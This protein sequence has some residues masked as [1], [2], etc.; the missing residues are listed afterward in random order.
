MNFDHLRKPNY[1]PA[2]VFAYFSE[3]CQTVQLSEAML[4]RCLPDEL[5]RSHFY[6]INHLARDGNGHTPLQ[7]TAA[8]QVTKTTIS[9]SLAVLEK[10]GFIETRRSQTDARSKQVF[11]TGSGRTFQKQ[12]ATAVTALFGSFLRDED[13]RI[14]GDALPSLVAIRKLLDENRNATPD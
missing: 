8:M 12:V 1:G 6:I 2:E 13:Y 4:D 14:M 9:H 10:Q 7:I 3:A 11:L 5:H